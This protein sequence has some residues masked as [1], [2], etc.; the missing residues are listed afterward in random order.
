M[1]LRWIEQAAYTGVR[2]HS[3]CRIRI[4]NGSYKKSADMKPQLGVEMYWILVPVLYVCLYAHES[5][6]PDSMD[7]PQPEYPLYRCPIPENR[8][9]I[10]IEVAD[11]C[12]PSLGQVK[13]HPQRRQKSNHYFFGKRGS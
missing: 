7:K 3:R 4:H 13:S 11:T 9:E 1:Q 2:G 12:P 8:P 5:P 10:A 6:V